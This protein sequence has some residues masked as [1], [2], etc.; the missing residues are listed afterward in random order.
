MDLLA[1]ADCCS[2]G[3]E[4]EFLGM[5]AGKW[6]NDLSQTKDDDREGDLLPDELQLREGKT[7]GGLNKGLLPTAKVWGEGTLDKDDVEWGLELDE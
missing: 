5:E 4:E 7:N 1:I 2:V 3:T 6:G